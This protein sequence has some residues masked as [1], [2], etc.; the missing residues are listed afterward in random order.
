MQSHKTKDIENPNA[1]TI[2]ILQEME[3]YYYS[4]RDEWRT[5]AY[6]KAM[7]TLRKQNHRITS[8]EEALQLPEIG[9][10]LASKIEEIV[11][12]NKLQRLEFAKM[13]PLDQV[14]EIFIKIYGVG[15]Q[16]ASKWVQEGYRTLDD[17]LTSPNV[18]LTPNQKVGIEHYEDFQLRIPRPETEQLARIV[19]SCLQKFDCE[20]QIMVGGSYRRGAPNSGDIDLIITQKDATAEDLRQVTT[21]KGVPWLEKVGFLTAGL[22]VTSKVDGSKWHGAC[23][24]PL[25]PDKLSIAHPN[26]PATNKNPWRR[27]DL[28]LV[29]WDE[30]G[31]AMIYFTGN[32]IFN[33]SMRLLARKKGM[34]LNQRGLY[35]DVMRKGAQKLNEGTKISGSDEKEI[36]SILGVPYRGPLERDC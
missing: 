26:V 34:R 20:L 15:F 32:D 25:N 22:A 27:I 23:Q 31:A 8:K 33:R 28:L 5:R 6:R 3:N 11:W 18:K 16:Q 35:K 19:K 14:M 30:L 7:A 9:E 1:K 17:L 10:R 2:A 4:I 21:E 29:P 24:L 12:T 13:E 36:F